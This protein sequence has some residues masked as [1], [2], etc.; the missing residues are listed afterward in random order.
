MNEFDFL[1]LQTKTHEMKNNN[2]GSDLYF[3]HFSLIRV[4]FVIV[5]T[6]KLWTVGENVKENI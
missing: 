4:F 1:I 5:L 3:D 6:K 2:K